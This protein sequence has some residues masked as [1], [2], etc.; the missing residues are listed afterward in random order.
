MAVVY[1]GLGSNIGDRFLY[2]QTA[3]KFLEKNNIHVRKLSTVIET[4]P[5]GGPQQN[6]F[7]NAA[8]QA[9]TT[10]LPKELLN[11]LKII[12]SSLGRT[13]EVRYGPRTIDI[14]ILLYNKLTLNEPDLKIPHPLIFKRDFVLKPLN[15]IAPHLYLGTR[16]AN[17][18]K[19]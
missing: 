1:L 7:L 3:L 9:E 8:L 4:N 17:H 14:D 12:E 15:E 2:I 16:Y 11:R 10:L 19:H 18:S 5:V 6:K 13:R